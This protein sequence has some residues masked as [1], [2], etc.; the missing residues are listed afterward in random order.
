LITRVENGDFII[1]PGAG[2]G[3][4]R[5]GTGRVCR[6]FLCQID[7]SAETAEIVTDPGRLWAVFGD[8]E[9]GVFS[10]SLRAVLAEGKRK[11]RINT[12]ALCEQLLTGAVTGHETIFEGIERLEGSGVLSVGGEQVTLHLR[13]QEGLD[14]QQGFSSMED[15]VEFQL[16]NLRAY[17]HKVN[18][19]AN[20]GRVSMGLSG[21]Y[22]S[23]LMLLLALEAGLNVLPFTFSSPSHGREQ[24]IAAIVAGHAGVELRRIPVRS[25][26]ALSASDLQ[27]NIDDALEYYDGRT[28]ETMGS[29]WDAH[30][31]RVHRKCVGEADLNLNGLGGELYRNRERLPPYS[32]SFREWFRQYVVGPGARGAFL[33]EKDRLAFENRLAAK[34]G[35]IL[36]EGK[37]VRLDRHMVRRWY[38]DVWL[39]YFAGPRLSAENRVG[40]ALM[41]FADG[42]VSAAAL[43][44]T[45]FIGAH[46]EFEA[47]MIRRLDEKIAALP[48]SY[49]PG[50]ARSSSGRR[51]Q[52][53]IMALVPLS[54]RVLRN[55]LL[56]R[57]R[58]GQSVEPRDLK[59]R[60]GTPLSFLKEM[61]LPL[62]I[63][64][65]VQDNRSQDRTLYMAEF[66]FRNQK[67]IDVGV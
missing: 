36:G 43:E 20:G 61:K 47:A 25:L 62:N 53:Q 9:I 63:E 37:L 4:P 18:E 66:L 59:I 65:L 32:F 10:S 64:Y 8:R 55:E 2:R 60:S 40:Q 6:Q 50:F 15:C 5:D 56:L 12:D 11:Y 26:N 23:R 29:F 41:P 42:G 52:D 17:F 45:P 16:E 48:S 7:S 54:T 28:N 67:Y 19:F 24:D 33:S 22:D 57:R 3:D 35:E 13:D 39:P 30:T 51:F 31:A 21:G 38:R 34:Y 58:G 1:M 49:G 46:G 27:T 44:A 14:S